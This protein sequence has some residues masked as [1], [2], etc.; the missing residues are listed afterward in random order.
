MIHRGP[1][2]VVG[3]GRSGTS[4]VARLLEEEL[5]VD[6]GG[7]GNLDRESNPRGDYEDPELKDLDMAFRRGHVTRARFEAQLR[8]IAADRAD[9]WGAK[10]PANATH[11]DA[12]LDVFPGAVLIWARRDLEDTAQSWIRWYGTDPEKARRVVGRRDQAIAELLTRRG[13]RV[14]HVTLNFTPYVEEG[15]LVEFLRLFL[16]RWGVLDEPPR[17]T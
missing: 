2:L 10:H 1:V 12:W 8:E 3:T 14:P 11:L 5:G 9:P 4:C 6:M 17:P 7:P 16:E 13:P 15:P